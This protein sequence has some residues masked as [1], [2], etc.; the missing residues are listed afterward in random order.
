MILLSYL[1]LGVVIGITATVFLMKWYN[2][3]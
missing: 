3:H 2:P 1:G